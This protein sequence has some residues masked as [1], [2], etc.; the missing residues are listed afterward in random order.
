MRFIYEEHF[1]L[2]PQNVFYSEVDKPPEMIVIIG[3]SYL[4]INL[5]SKLR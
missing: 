5:R 3:I 4:Y 2:S 1:S